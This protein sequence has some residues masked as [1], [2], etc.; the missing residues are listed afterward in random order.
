MA[1]VY[2][3]YD[4]RN[5]G[6]HRVPHTDKNLQTSGFQR[7]PKKRLD[8]FVFGWMV[9]VQVLSALLI[10]IFFKQNNHLFVFL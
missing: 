4:F 7:S 5:Y 9:C 3:K 1:H 10:Y 2:S 6:R 8:H